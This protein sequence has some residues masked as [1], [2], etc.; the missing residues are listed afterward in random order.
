MN[1]AGRIRLLLSNR[2]TPRF[3]CG[4]SGAPA[5]RSRKPPRLSERAP[6]PRPVNRVYPGMLVR[7]RRGPSSPGGIGPGQSHTTP[8]S[9]RLTPRPW[10]RL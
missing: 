10:T 5:P 3:L 8:R 4:L 2:K 9:S 1:D 6:A 7:L